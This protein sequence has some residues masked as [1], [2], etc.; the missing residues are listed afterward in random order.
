M[1]KHELEEFETDQL[2]DDETVDEEDE[3]VETSDGLGEPEAE[4]QDDWAGAMPPDLLDADPYHAID[5][6]AAAL[7]PGAPLF[8]LQRSHQNAK[9]LMAVVKDLSLRYHAA[10]HV[11]L[12]APMA[13][14]TPDGI[15]SFLTAGDPAAVRIADPEGF[16]RADSYGQVLH[17]QRGEKP[18]IGP[19]RAKHWSYITDA[20]PPGGSGAWVEQAL[21]AQREAGA[22]V[23]LTP[24]VW[25]D[26]A[27]AAQSLEIMRQHVT[28]AREAMTPQE[29]LAVNM[30]L[31]YSWLSTSRLRDALLDEILDMD[32]QVFY[33]RVRWPLMPQPY[34]H[35]LDPTVLAG[36][37]EL[38]N[39]FDENDRTLILPNTGATGWLALAW[40]AHGYSTGMGAHE[41]AFADTRVIRIK[42]QSPRPE[43]TKRIYV[44][45]LLHVTDVATA[46]RVAALPAQRRCECGFCQRQRKQPWSKGLADAHYLRQMADMTAAMS[47][48]PRGRRV[49]ARKTV[50]DAAAF[51]ALANQTVPLTAANDPRHLAQWASLLS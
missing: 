15:R 12:V 44:P 24:G 33:L 29:H 32:E 5:E 28:W 4:D 30:T 47:N 42:T 31:P 20:I 19:S 45:S 49:R 13:R 17:A 34:G 39:V 51:S 7:S 21:D 41:R 50:K 25:A 8:L 38:C 11:G 22:T 23:L 2:D 48:D 27:T 9:L 18:Y 14:M 35:L 37:R 43:P 36:Y 16:A 26:P 10:L 1:T 40:G 46:D 3:D 6:V